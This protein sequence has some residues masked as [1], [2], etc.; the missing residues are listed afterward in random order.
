MNEA[1]TIVS[2]DPSGM[3]V[4][5][6]HKKDKA[7][8]GIFRHPSGVWA[9]RFTCGAGHLHKQKVGPLKTD[10]IRTYH[11][12]RARAHDEPGWCPATERQRARANASLDAERA[13]ARILF[14]VF[15]DEQYLPHATVHK[16]SWRTDESRIAY[17]VGKIGNKRLDEITS[18]DVDAILLELRAERQPGTVN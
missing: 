8:R 15:A 7:P 5:S 18:Q 3:P 17:L 13:R 16:R 6:T 1:M 9:V 4:R 10:S 12:R 14:K 2:T 11:E